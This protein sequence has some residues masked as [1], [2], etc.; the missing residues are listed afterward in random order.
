MQRIPQH[1]ATQLGLLIYFPFF[2]QMPTS[3]TK[4][5]ATVNLVS[6]FQEAINVPAVKAMWQQKDIKNAK[7]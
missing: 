6:T 7:V 1:D 5:F 3:V 2:F 4:I